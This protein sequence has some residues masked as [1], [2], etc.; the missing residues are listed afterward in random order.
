[1]KYLSYIGF[2]DKGSEGTGRF[3]D[4]F[5]GNRHGMLTV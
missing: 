1:M 4:Y 2:I 5:R 3:A